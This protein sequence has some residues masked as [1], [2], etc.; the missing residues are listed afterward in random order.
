MADIEFIHEKCKGCCL[1]VAE[2]PRANIRMAEMLNDAGVPYA[3]VIDI[4]NCTGCALCCQICPDLAI[5][6]NQASGK[7]DILD[8]APAKVEKMNGVIST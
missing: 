2:C 7:R 1:C 4:E 3:E 8:V 6:I 5:R